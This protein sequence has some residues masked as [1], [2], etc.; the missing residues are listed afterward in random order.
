M[1]RIIVLVLA[2]LLVM[3]GVAFADVKSN[4]GIGDILGQ[5]KLQSDPHRIF[6][7]VRWG[8]GSTLSADTIVVWDVTADDGVTITTTTTSRDSTVAGIIV[9]S[10]LSPDTA[11]TTAVQDRGKRNW[12]WLQ[13]Y[14]KSDV[15]VATVVTA[16]NAMGTST[17]A[18]HATTFVA[19]T[20]NASVNGNA[21]F[22]FDTANI[23]DASVECFIRL[24]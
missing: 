23:G 4:P 14:G 2:I 7:M 6:R 24:D 9:S 15:S 8:G 13:T 17:T 18:G 11:S 22:F 1:K 16:G 12:T 20:N 10:S 21:G 19:S 3:S 5:G